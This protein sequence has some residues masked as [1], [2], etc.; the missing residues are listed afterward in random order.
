MLVN[1]A[2]VVGTASGRKSRGAYA[3]TYK[4]SMTVRRRVYLSRAFINKSPACSMLILEKIGQSAGKWTLV[5]SQADALAL[6]AKKNTQ[7]QVVCLATPM[8]K[9]SA[10]LLSVEKKLCCADV[11]SFFGVIDRPRSSVVGWLH[12]VV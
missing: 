1:E 12:D 3:L 7:S 6:H 9:A 5:R 8:E 11:P 10:A 2:Y 4:S